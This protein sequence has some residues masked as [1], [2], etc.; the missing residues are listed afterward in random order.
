MNQR[1]SYGSLTPA[2]RWIANRSGG[3]SS[4]PAAD[5]AAYRQGADFRVKV[6]LTL[7]DARVKA[8]WGFLNVTNAVAATWVPTIGKESL[9]FSLAT[10]RLTLAERTMPLKS[11]TAFDVRAADGA[12]HRMVVYTRDADLVRIVFAGEQAA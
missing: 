8:K 4:S 3:K 10:T 6:M 1:T 11:V 2:K 12:V 7:P 9:S 5:A